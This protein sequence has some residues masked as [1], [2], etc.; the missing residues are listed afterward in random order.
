MS[1]PAVTVSS[2]DVGVIVYCAEL[3]APTLRD[4]ARRILEAEATRSGV[5]LGRTEVLRRRARGGPAM[6]VLAAADELVRHLGRRGRPARPGQP[7]HCP[8]ARGSA[9]AGEQG[10]TGREPLALPPPRALAGTGRGGGRSTRL[11]GADALV[12]GPEYAGD[13]GSYL[14]KRPMPNSGCCEFLYSCARPCAKERSQRSLIRHCIRIRGAPNAEYAHQA[15]V[16]YDRTCT[17]RWSSSAHRISGRKHPKIQGEPVTRRENLSFG[18]MPRFRQP[19]A[20]AS[21]FCFR[22][23]ELTSDIRAG[24]VTVVKPSQRQ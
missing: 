11:R 22:M 8:G 3:E 7:A 23:I 19:R 5:P 1:V 13:H 10:G 6:H 15:E 12:Y 24:V 9:G 14:D 20:Q 2:M 16:V 17:Y 4:T 18:S 21:I